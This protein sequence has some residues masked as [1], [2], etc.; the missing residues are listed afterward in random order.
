MTAATATGGESR[1]PAVAWGNGNSSSK[2]AVRTEWMVWIGCFAS[3]WAVHSLL[4][5]ASN[6]SRRERWWHRESPDGPK[7]ESNV[8][9][10][11]SYLFSRTRYSH[12][13]PSAH[14]CDDSTYTD[15]RTATTRAIPQA[16]RDEQLSRH[17]LFFGDAGLERLKG[18]RV[19]IV[20]VGGVGSHTAHM[21]ARSG[22]GHVRL[23][24]MDY[25]TLSS[26]NRHACA[27]LDDVGT[28][29]VECLARFLRRICPDP[30]HLKIET[31]AEMYT[32]ETGPRLL[33]L[34][35]DNGSDSSSSSWDMVIDCIDDVPTK[36]ALL[37]Y[38]I[39]HR[40]RVLSCMGAGGKADPTRLHISDLSSATRDPLAT[41]IRNT[42][43]RT[44]VSSND[45]AKA[46]SYLEDMD[47][48][49]ILYSSEKTVVK[50]ADF[51][52]DQKEH[53][54]HQFGAIDG[55]RI[56]IIPVLGTMPAI[57]GQALASWSLT[58]IAATSTMDRIIQP[59]PV[60]RVGRTTR[61]KL[62]QI[63]KSREQAFTAYIQAQTKAAQAESL[64]TSTLATT[65]IHGTGELVTIGAD[66][67]NSTVASTTAAVWIGEL[68]IDSN[69]DVEYLLEIWRNRCAITGAR[70][71]TVLHLVRWDISLPSKC[72]NLV[73][74]S[75]NVL[76]NFT[77]AKDVEYTVHVQLRDDYRNKMNPVAKKRIE[78]T[79]ASCRIDR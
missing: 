2:S 37:S 22:V 74:V 20:G 78:D 24:D 1:R 36:A 9:G 38:C 41:K 72:D 32:A 40:I 26:L 61:H 46:P 30:A 4:L 13:P 79:L 12:S 55:M 28:S 77:A 68:Q 59:V 5:L 75:A 29:K 21:L 11:F 23:I 70:L 25:V 62:Y 3:G 45:T 54:V 16:I 52:D 58:C 71:G 17:A 76:Q 60:E 64:P 6:G 14:F 18:S 53:G 50:L 48:C 57:M 34:P 8:W 42:L 66:V 49:T 35:T 43:K 69:D 51:T 44:L 56:R 15:D 33:E 31:R 7:G 47:Q 73:L 65:S 10:F 67:A 19:C 63:L 27:V 39:Q